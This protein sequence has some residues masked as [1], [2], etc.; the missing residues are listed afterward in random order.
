MKAVFVISTLGAGGAERAMSELARFLAGHGWSI[1]LASFE[2]ETSVDFFSL[3]PAVR[4]ARLGNPRPARSLAG[5]LAANLRRA[6]ALRALIA[7]EKPGVVL[8]FMET[9]NVL[10]LIASAGLQVPVVVAERTDPSQHIAV[11]KMW[12]LGRRWLYRRASSVV[13][14]TESAA[15]W[16]RRHCHCAVQVIP[17]ALRELPQ[18]GGGREPLLLS[19]GRL[20][21]VKGFDVILHAFARV[22]RRFPAWRVVIVGDGSLRDELH[23]LAQELDVAARVDWLGRRSDIEHWYAR[24][25]LVAQASRFEGFPNVL[26]E[27]MGMGAAVISTDC[28]SG[29]REIITHGDNGWLV[30]VDDVTAMASGMQALMANE[31]ARQSLGRSAMAVRERF[32]PAS[33]LGQWERLLMAARVPGKEPQ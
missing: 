21:A 7:H 27:A 11:P 4:R 16:L 3:H 2:A 20:E 13:A 31:E 23:A 18:P 29:P 17:N 6:L 28:R 25:G 33:I 9:S 12:R 30:P 26:L 1:V 8:S 5:K 10:A 32:A 24:A 22:S 19:V 15:D 14:Q